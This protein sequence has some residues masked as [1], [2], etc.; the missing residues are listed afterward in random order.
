MITVFDRTQIRKQRNRASSH[1]SERDFLFRW[2]MEQIE[3]RLEIIRRDFPS[4]LQIG[5]RGPTLPNHKNILRT[6]ITQSLN[7]DIVCDE[8]FMPFGNHTFDLVISALN[9]H[10]VNDLPGSLLQINRMLKPDG[11]FL[12]AMLGGETLHELR[13]CFQE[14]EVELTGG[15]SPRIAPFADK[16]QMGALLQR[17]GF[18]LPVVDSEIVTVTYETLFHLMYDLRYMGEGNAVTERMKT[19]TPRGF[20]QKAAE[21]Y[22][23][24]YSEPDGRLCATFEIIFMLGWAPHSSQQKPLKPGS[25]STRLA[26]F[27]GTDEIGTGEK[28]N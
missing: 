19:A 28:P 9:L 27:L 11:L 10:T 23:Q 14:V 6:D 5:S 1:M 12:A 16:Q 7:P 3:D 13:T 26:D 17:A 8:E 4:I 20:F 15:L 22:A 18:A 25:A 2:T 21:L 24:K